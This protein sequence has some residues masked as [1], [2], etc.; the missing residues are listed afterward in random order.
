M[1]LRFEF[2]TAF[3]FTVLWFIRSPLL[4]AEVEKVP[5]T[6]QLDVVHQELS[7]AH[8]WFH[9]R[10]A[11]LPGFGRNGGPAVIMTIQKHLVADDH[12]S[13]LYFLRTD[14]LGGAWTG[15]TEIP[16]LGWG[17][18]PGDVTISVA[19]VTPGWHAATG[20]MISIG[21]KVRYSQ[22]GAQLLDRPRSNEC[23]YAVYDPA[24]DT[25]SKW[26]FLQMPDTDSK[27]Y[28][29][30]PGCVQWLVKDDGSLLVPVYFRGPTGDD[31]SVTV[32]H[33]GFDG[34]TLTYL[35]HGD[36]LALAGGR[37]LAE[38]SLALYHGKYFLTLRNDARGYVTT[39]DDGLSYAPIRPWTFDDGQEL[40]SYNT[41][42]H[43]LVH[44]DGLFLSYTR[45]GANNDH[46]ARNRAPLFLAQVDPDRLAVLRETEQAI[47]PERGVMLGNFGAAAISPDES[48]VTDAEFIV[49]E[50]P[51]AR[52]A[53]GS[54]YAARV[55]WSR[56]NR[57]AAAAGNLRL[58]SQEVSFAQP[59]E[60]R[61][62]YKLASY[63][64]PCGP[65][66]V[67]IRFEEAK[68]DLFSDYEICTSSDHGRTWSPTQAWES[69][70]TTP[71]GTFRRTILNTPC[72]DSGSGRL[73]IVGDEGVLR[74]DSS[75]DGLTQY[76]QVY[77]VSNDQ[78]R[79]WTPPERVIQAGAEFTPDHP[80]PGVW[81]G[82]VSAMT[83]NA[84]L[85]RSDGAVLVP[86]QIGVLEGGKLFLPPGA[87]TFLDSAMLIGKWQADGRLTWTLG[88]RVHLPP[89]KS[90]RGIFEPTVAEWPDGRLLMIMRANDG[91][92][93]YALSG[94]GGLT[95]DEPRHWTYAG[96][97]E[98]YS[99]S[100]ISRLIRHSDGTW[101]WIGNICGEPPRGNA[102]RYPLV[103]GRVDPRSLLLDRE[104]L[105]TIDERKEGDSPG[106]QLS[107]F[108]VEEDRL[109]GD[110]LLRMTRWDGTAS[111]TGQRVR[112]DVHLYRMGR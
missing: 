101:Y 64:S 81:I 12:Y 54:T 91:H 2:A 46:I 78:G 30:C 100:S 37:G 104:S 48:W 41:Q 109:T 5:F 21:T 9:P 103:I 51:H 10:V 36:E 107:N 32:L 98:F 111:G 14:D 17:S 60:D 57:L 31:Y 59:H 61:A 38:P 102:P 15:P 3:L 25:W 27:F 65:E 108:G 22:A 71:D 73:V 82:Q 63:A 8:C 72:C 50:K 53:D 96:G 62:A 105:V 92:K 66:M 93:W 42:Q 16:E 11:A 69:A 26:K 35:E 55:R 34:E 13:G 99:P 74:N 79:T 49:S 97:G 110:L 84:F 28:L 7:P 83:A 67:R 106:L 24:A 86:L 44:S 112:G 95:W 33:L 20:K 4:A 87:F 39:S 90:L 76:Y 94:D 19:D 70:R 47:M 77:T 1:K 43:W 89:E 52:G 68:D 45:R 40:G 85:R 6:V 80:L 18:E 23:A 75:L 56:P 58:K 88:Q 29:V